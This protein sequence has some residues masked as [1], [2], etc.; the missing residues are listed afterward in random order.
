MGT[1]LFSGG[2][3]DPRGGTTAS[4]P[5]GKAAPGAEGAPRQS[6]ARCRGSPAAKQRPALTSSASSRTAATGPRDMTAVP[7]RA[8]T[9][10]DPPAA[11][12]GN[13]GGPWSGAQVAAGGWGVPGGICAGRGQEAPGPGPRPA[14]GGESRPRPARGGSAGSAG[15][16][17]P[18]ASEVCGLFVPLPPRKASRS[19]QEDC[20]NKLILSGVIDRGER[21]LTGK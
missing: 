20:D 3:R 12:H 9:G 8:G 11:Q 2:T 4:P 14:R 7:C 6:S 19:V 10:S 17:F 5:R 1:P 13:A 18:G 21:S 15:P 16:G